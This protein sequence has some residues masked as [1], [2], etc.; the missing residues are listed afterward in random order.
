ML[1][2]SPICADTAVTF[3]SFP[4]IR[5]EA[6]TE[7]VV[8]AIEKDAEAVEMNPEQVQEQQEVQKEML[9]A[10]EEFKKSLEDATKVE[11]A[12]A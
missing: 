6:T 3:I 1:F 5:M 4:N 7:T 9:L 12:A 8:P 2:I 11:K 10:L